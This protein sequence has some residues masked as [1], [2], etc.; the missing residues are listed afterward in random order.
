[1][2]PDFSSTHPSIQPSSKSL[3][4]IASSI[5][6]PKILAKH[7]GGGRSFRINSN[8]APSLATD[9]FVLTCV[10][11]MVAQQV[12]LIIA[13]RPLAADLAFQGPTVG[14]AHRHSIA[15]QPPAVATTSCTDSRKCGPFRWPALTLKRVREE[16]S[17]PLFQ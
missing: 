10:R 9:I 14:E 16:T 13:P 17:R 2:R 8:R 12:P 4:V 7:C 1:M 5:V 15:N 6:S 3:H 11:S